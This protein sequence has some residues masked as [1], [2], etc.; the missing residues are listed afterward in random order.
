MP[1]YIASIMECGLKEYGIKA[2]KW[3]G[4]MKWKNQKES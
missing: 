1:G 4:I 2:R 3:V